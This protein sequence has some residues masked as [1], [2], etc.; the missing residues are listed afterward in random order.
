[1]A[2][3]ITKKEYKK[4]RMRLQIAAGLADFVITAGCVVVGFICV[5][6]LIQLYSWLKGDVPETFKVFFT[7]AERI[8]RVNG[9]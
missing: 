8:L 4:R 5:L 3:L 2:K 6:L 9:R 1:M 7:M